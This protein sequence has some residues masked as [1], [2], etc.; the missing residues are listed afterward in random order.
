MTGN[1]EERE[2][3]FHQDTKKVLERIFILCLLFDV[4]ITNFWPMHAYR[5]E[6]SV[7]TVKRKVTKSFYK[8]IR[9][10]FERI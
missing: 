3:F 6:R 9:C 8:I 10:T 7:T 5:F 1:H 2:V 4:P